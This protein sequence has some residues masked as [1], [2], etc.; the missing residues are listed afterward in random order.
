MFSGAIT[1]LTGN[2]DLAFYLAGLFIACS[3]LLMMLLPARGKIRK[4]RAFR[5]RCQ[6][7]GEEDD[8]DDDDD[9]ED[10]GVVDIEKCLEKCKPPGIK[11]KK[12][13]VI[14]IKIMHDSTHFCN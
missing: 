7:S 5:R 11:R 8:D 9:E 14:S 1:D 10:C 6:S 3:G 13:K 12:V 4:Y 2:Y